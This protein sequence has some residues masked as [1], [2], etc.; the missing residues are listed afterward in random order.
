MTGA[1]VTAPPPSAAA[2]E[3]SEGRG[4]RAW[5]W[6]ASQPALAAALVYAVLSVVFVGQGLLPDR[7]L[8][9]LGHA[10]EHRRRGPAASPPGVRS[11]WART[12]SWPTPSQ[13]SSRSSSTRARVLPRRP[14]VEPAHHGRAGPFLANAQSAVFSPFTVPAYVL[15][16]WTA[17][18]VMA[19]LKLFVA[20]FGTY[21]L[22]R[23][24]GMRFGGALLAGVVFAFGTFFVAWLA[25]P[26]TNIFPLIPWLLL[27]TELLVRRPGPLPAAGLA[28]LVALQFF[29]GHPETSF[30]VMVATIVF[31]AFRGAARGRRRPARRDAGAPA[32]AFAA[33]WAAGR[34]ARGGH[35]RAAARAASC[36]RATTR[37]ASD[38]E[39]GSSA[40]D[41]S[42]ALFLPDYW[43]RADADPDRCRSC[44]NRGYYAGGITLMLAAAA[45][46]LR[47]TVTARGGRRLR[48]A[49][50]A[51]VVGVDRRSCVVTALPG[52]STAHNGRL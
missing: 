29:G 36:T 39:P 15:G 2:P 3:R 14:A 34:G 44:S 22:G 48:R 47:P 8:V 12:S 45:L 11:G 32:L 41:T 20:A 21:L 40:P 9:E 16:L 1:P 38:A 46:I 49:S 27:L 51:V 25:W 4:R 6:W 43:G 5:R 23:A 52:F 33:R 31:F 37:G 17:L 30:H 10:L 50:L 19:V 7:T 42:G 13:C 26:L 28:V 18:A 24:L 35:A